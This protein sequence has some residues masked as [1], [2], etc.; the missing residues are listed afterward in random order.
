[1]ENS[2]LVQTIALLNTNELKWFKKFLQSKMFNH[3]EELVNLFIHLRKQLVANHPD[4]SKQK[5]FQVIFGN[6][7]YNNTL[8]LHKVS[9]LFKCLERFLAFNELYS[10]QHTE[11][12]A[13]CRAYRKLN[14]P[15][16]VKSAIQK[17]KKQLEATP[18]RN[19]DYHLSVFQ[20][21]ME[22]F[23]TQGLEKRSDTT[24]LQEINDQ[25]D[26][27]YFAQKLRQCC[28]MITHQN[29]FKAEFELG[30]AQNV[31]NEV[32][33]KQLYTIP[34]IGIYYY[35]YKALMDSENIQAFKDLQNQL[36]SYA[37]L[38]DPIELGQ[39]YLLAINIGIK[40]LN[41]G[42]DQLMTEILELYKTGI[43]SNV[44][45]FNNRLSRFTYKNTVTLAIRLKKFE[46]VAYFLTKF[47]DFLDPNYQ[48]ESYN[49]GRAHLL[50][51]QKNYAGALQLLFT[52]VKSDDVFSNLS[53]KV[54][55]SRIYYEQNEFDSLEAQINS[56]KSFIRRKNMI[57]YQQT[58]YQNFINMMNKLIRLNP[59]DKSAKT[60][61]REE[62]EVLEPL[63]VKYWFLEQV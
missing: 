24:N 17:T 42:E 3:N 58:H 13:L 10:D 38:F 31:I 28:L 12:I 49:Y 63:P 54:L 21:E 23:T 40:F 34:A 22:A 7:S 16:S 37:E 39:Q 25:L 35:S 52:N 32:E 60:A 41:R 26:I 53:T 14:V 61:L 45:V 59:Y 11:S 1:M 20:L 6:V 46:W 43:E 51:A 5:A 55:L 4:F 56:F 2:K 9:H 44:L 36:V 62:I 27:T 33:Q 8:F 48:E 29:V 30:I 50:Y 57:T 19:I 47:K 15:K 18:K